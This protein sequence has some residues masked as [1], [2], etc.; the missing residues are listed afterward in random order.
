V[1]DGK[2]YRIASV[3]RRSVTF[4]DGEGEAVTAQVSGTVYRDC[5]PVVGD[6][7]EVS[8]SRKDPV[9]TGIRPRTSVLERTAPLGER[10]QVIAAN[11]DAVLV[12]ASFESPPFRRG[13][14][15]RTLV[16]AGWRDL[17]S[18]LVVNKVDLVSTDGDR[19]V[20]ERI[21]ADYGPGGAGCRVFA[22]SCVTGRGIEPLGAAL[23]G[24][25]VVMTGQSGTGKTTLAGCLNPSLDLVTGRTNLK[26]GKGRHT[27]VKARLLPLGRDTFMIDTPGLRMF[28][29]DHVPADELRDCFREF[30]DLQGDCRFRDCLHDSEPGCAVRE[31]VESGRVSPE[32]YSSYLGLLAELRG[33]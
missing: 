22:V 17:E 5:H 13:F 10:R 18:W 23:E 3:S 19:A 6:V 27:T 11:V 21:L 8:G 25:T 9:V 33:T 20:L 29:V 12:V 30:R 28:S 14:V 15:D 1:N 16:S 26:T 4:L 32:R 7:A 24:L 2:L 31:A